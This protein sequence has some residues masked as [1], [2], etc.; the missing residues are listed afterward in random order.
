MI[1]ADTRHHLT[2]DDAQLAARILAGT[3]ATSSRSSRRAWPT[4]ASTRS[5]TIRACPRALLRHPRGAHASF[6]LF[7]YV[8][9]RHALRSAGEGDRGLADYV[10]VDRHS[11]RLSRPRA[12]RVAGR[13]RGLR[14]DRAA[15]RRPQRSGRAPQLSRADASRQLR[16]VVERHL[17]RLH[18]AASLAAR[19]AGSRVLRGDGTARLPARRRPSPRRGAR[20]R[21]AVRDGGRSFRRASRAL[22]AV[23][24][25]LFF[26]NVQTPERL[27]R[28]VRDEARWRLDDRECVSRDRSARTAS[29]NA[30]NRRR[31]QSSG[32]A[33]SS[34]GCHWTATIHQAG[35]RRLERLDD[36]VVARRAS[37][38]RPSRDAVDRLMVRRV[39]RDR[40]W[41]RGRARGAIPARP[42]TRCTRS[43]AAVG[44][45]VVDAARPL[46]R[47]CPARACRRARRS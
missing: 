35:S 24:D 7:A 19:R 32:V 9:I 20:P 34:S 11:L 4:R 45:V 6:T 46:R 23:S 13:R 8:M 25:T 21:D 28:Q 30:A 16:A 36:S 42:S 22:N 1:L 37:T 17:S 12:S 44:L 43:V 5:S 47:E 27:M 10:S 18:R 14:R 2:R 39:R 3:R 31:S 33:V 41:R 40:R 15:L 26:P 29:A 38:R